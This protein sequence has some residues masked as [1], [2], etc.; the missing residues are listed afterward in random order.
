MKPH[1]T[2][3]DR[4]NTMISNISAFSTVPK[5]DMMTGD[6]GKM[7]KVA[8]DNMSNDAQ[9]NNEAVTTYQL[10]QQTEVVK[11]VFGESSVN[12]II[13]DEPSTYA[14]KCRDYLNGGGEDETFDTSDIEQN[15]K[16]MYSFLYQ[17]DTLVDN[18]K[19][20]REAY[21]KGMENIEKEYKKSYDDVV[22]RYKN[23]ADKTT[24]KDN[25]GQ[26]GS[27]LNSELN[28]AKQAGEEADRKIKEQYSLVYGK[29][30]N[31]DGAKI[32][33][34]G[35]NGSQQ[36]TNTVVPKND[37]NSTDTKALDAK[38]KATNKDFKD[39]TS[40]TKS[41]NKESSNATSAAGTVN[42]LD[43]VSAG[44]TEEQLAQ[45]ETTSIDL[46]RAFGNARSLLMGAALNALTDTRNDFMAI[47]RAHV[48]S[49]VGQTEGPDQSPEE[50]QN[51]PTGKL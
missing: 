2:G 21:D 38:N 15:M 10:E 6:N 45:F 3:L 20:I 13:G 11:K 37:P 28:K 22:K 46:L 5:F 27:D 24:F 36:S 7:S 17:Q 47:V 44:A 43:K 18:L 26:S 50:K 48:R 12:E 31:E 51:M 1:F 25:I 42:A 30:I 35:S 49:W 8:S 19:K 32:T 40:T 39:A 23:S 41:N 34:G 9:K 16:R 29:V 14:A 33:T 4:F